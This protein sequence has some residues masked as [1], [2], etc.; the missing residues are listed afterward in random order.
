MQ[1]IFETERLV[2]RRYT[3]GD[4]EKFFSLNGDE[5]VVRFIRAVQTKEESDRF[6]E[7]NISFYDEEPLMG[8]WAVQEKS[9]GSFVGSFAIIFIPGSKEI[10]LGYA[11]LKNEWGKGYATELV[12]AGLQ[13]VFNTM[14]LPFVFAVTEK[15][16]TGSQHVLLK[17]GFK[18]EKEYT[19]GEK[20]LFRFIIYTP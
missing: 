8:R 6:L 3:P 13:Y 9:S 19:E 14:K 2:V 1:S 15:E 4:K 12:K 5:E 18:M 17:A 16:N 20:E 7:E 10:Q 11:L